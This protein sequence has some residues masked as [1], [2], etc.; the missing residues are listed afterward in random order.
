[1][2]RLSDAEIRTLG[3][4]ATPW[5]WV[6]FSDELRQSLA[7]ADAARTAQPRPALPLAIEGELQPCAV[8]GDPA[9]PSA[10]GSP[11]CSAVCTAV[12]ADSVLVEIAPILLTQADGNGGSEPRRPP[13]RKPVRRAPAGDD[14]ASVEQAV[15]RIGSCRDVLERHGHHVRGRMAFCPLH[16]HRHR[17]P[18]M[19]LYERD[20]RSRFHCH[21]C[22]AHGDALDLEAELSGT[23]LSEVIRGWGR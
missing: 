19:S 23:E 13:K 14:Q 12:L 11:T 20:G 7:E 18:S 2:A 22:G 16:E 21:A 4:E 1:M 17:T 9:E 10:V 5:G 8:C 6:P 3:Y 15:S